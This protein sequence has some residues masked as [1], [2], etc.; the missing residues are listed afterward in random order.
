MPFAQHVN[1]LKTLFFSPDSWTRLGR[2][3]LCRTEPVQA[4]RVQWFKEHQPYRFN[5]RLTFHD[6]PDVGTYFTVRLH[7]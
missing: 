5:P 3:A 6:V 2:D 7:F 1:T 4:P